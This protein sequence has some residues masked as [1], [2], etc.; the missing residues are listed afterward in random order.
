MIRL[1]RYA[2]V[3][4]TLAFGLYHA[5]LGALNF[6][7]YENQSLALGAL[8]I[9]LVA[10]AVSLLD[11]PGLALKLPF[12]Y[13]KLLASIAIPVLMALAIEPELASGYS[14]WHVAG[15]ATLMGITAVRQHRW[16]AWVGVSASVVEVLAWGSFGKLFTSGVIGAVM[17]VAAAHAASN[18][19]AA[20]SKAASEYRE[21]ELTNTA[22]TA[23]K[24]AARNERRFRLEQALKSALPQLQGIVA[25]K[26]KLPKAQQFEALLTEGFL[27][28]QIR[29]RNLITPELNDEVRNA[30]IRGVE[31]QLLDD[32]GLDDMDQARKHELLSQVAIQLSQINAG[33]VVIRS[34]AGE[35]WTISMAAIRK[36]ADRPDLF[37]RI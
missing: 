22:A 4:F 27:R 13:F 16:I 8:L 30:R 2:L 6:E 35:E 18:V 26:G 9:Y 19:L 17:L 37:I 3:G 36:E 14:T 33:R 32:G 5:V 34:V 7:Y 31:V 10:L 23:A 25:R 24:S 20:S 15:I 28:D 21:Q 1:P 12:A 29:G 11:Q